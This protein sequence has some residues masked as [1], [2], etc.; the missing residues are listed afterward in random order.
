M[1]QQR[2]RQLGL[3]SSSYN[4]LNKTGVGILLHLGAFFYNPF[5]G[6][7]IYSLLDYNINILRTK[8]KY[9][10]GRPPQDDHDCYESSS[11]KFRNIMLSYYFKTLLWPRETGNDTVEG[12]LYSQDTAVIMTGKF[13]EEQDVDK[14][15]I[16]RY[17][18]LKLI[19]N[20]FGKIAVSFHTIQF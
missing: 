8:Y 1:I 16:N 11:C 9:V 12:I 10:Q 19:M 18:F 15:K 14:N 13:V 6:F 20:F 7:I 4:S 2:C 17:I 5:H 3:F